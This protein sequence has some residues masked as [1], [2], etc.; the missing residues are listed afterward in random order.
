VR[1]AGRLGYQADQ[2]PDVT[3]ESGLAPF[4]DEHSVAVCCD[5]YRPIRAPYSQL[6]WA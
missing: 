4:A 5:R 6:I 2:V 3:R 1:Q